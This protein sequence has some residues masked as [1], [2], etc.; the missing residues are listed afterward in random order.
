[1]LGEIRDLETGGIAIKAALTGHL[2]LSTLHTNSAPETVT[3]LMDMGIEP[4]NVASAL[5]LVLAQ[6]LVRRVCTK[7]AEAY[8]MEKEEIAAA[9]VDHGVTLRD[10][11]FT[12][13]ALNDAKTRAT[14]AAKPFMDQITLDTKMQDIPVFRGKGCEQCEGSGLRGRQGLYEVLNM[15]PRLRKLIMQSAGAAEIQKVA[16]EEGMLT[17]RMDGWLKVLKGITTLDQVVRETAADAH[18]THH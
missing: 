12:D 8:K 9:K 13:M 1:M 11:H 16:I 14:E 10:L 18:P 2:V 3:R 7:C 5:N 6:R 4:F 15:T 17:L